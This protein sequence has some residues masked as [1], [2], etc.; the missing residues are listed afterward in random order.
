MDYLARVVLNSR[1][2]LGEGPVIPFMD[3]SAIYDRELYRLLTTA[4]DEA[5]NKWQTKQRIAGGTDAGSVQRSTAG[6]RTAAL[7]TAMRNIHTPACIAKISD[8]EDMLRLARLFLEK[9]SEDI[10]I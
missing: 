4:A 6:V 7:S 1:C 3:G 8:F 2:A 5:G 10:E 9:L